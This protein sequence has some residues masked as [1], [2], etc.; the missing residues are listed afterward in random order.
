MAKADENLIDATV[1]LDCRIIALNFV[2]VPCGVP[3]WRVAISLSCAGRSKAKVPNATSANPIAII[4]TSLKF[5]SMGFLLP[6]SDVSH[7]GKRSKQAME[8]PG[9]GKHGKP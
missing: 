6:L 3:I 5:I 9:Y 8:M 1:V 2:R 4:T 7:H